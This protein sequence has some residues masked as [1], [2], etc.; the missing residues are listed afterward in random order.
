MKALKNSA[1]QSIAAAVKQRVRGQ[2]FPS[3]AICA[4]LMAFGSNGVSQGLPSLKAQAQF[5]R[6]TKLDDSN[7]PA[8]ENSTN[9]LLHKN[10]AE[11]SKPDVITKDGFVETGFDRL[12]SFQLVLTNFIWD[13]TRSLS[14][15][16]VAGEIPDGVKSLDKRR[17]ALKGFM[18]PVKLEE[19][20]VT[21]FML[22]KN[23]LVCCF[24]GMPQIND[25]VYVRMGAK[26]VKVCMDQPLTVYGTLHIGEFHHPNGV[27]F[28]IYQLGGEKLELPE[29]P[30]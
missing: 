21:E 22:L 8:Q 7:P 9:A 24:G 4:T 19:G 30:K 17:V 28:G 1:S 11:V 27:Q 29:D 13:T 15:I 6:G 26:G 3:I 2:W 5:V 20:R 25:W 18:M 12:S 10:I 14:V 16:K 23:Q